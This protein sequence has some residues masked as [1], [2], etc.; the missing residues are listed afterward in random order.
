MISEMS[1]L[2]LQQFV[3]AK[4]ICH[5]GGHFVPTSDPH[6][7][8]Y[9]S[10]LDDRKDDIENEN[11]RKQK[12]IQVGSYTLERMED[13]GSDHSEDD[14]NKCLHLEDCSDKV[15][16]ERVRTKSNKGRISK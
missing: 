14:K 11:R 9:T 3:H 10:F 5:P 2:L 8:G 13:C 7:Q 16:E 6:R 1:E 12:Q 15:C 4:V